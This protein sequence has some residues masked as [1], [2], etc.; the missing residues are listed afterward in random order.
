M[1]KGT[2]SLDSRK[3]EDWKKTYIMVFAAASFSISLSLS[4][5]DFEIVLLAS[6]LELEFSCFASLSDNLVF[7]AYLSYNLS[8]LYR[9]RLRRED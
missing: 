8:D 1:K 7:F 9:F 4:L 3:N 5:N 6:R 2:V